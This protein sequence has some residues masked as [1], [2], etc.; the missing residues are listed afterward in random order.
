MQRKLE[1]V[2]IGFSCIGAN[3]GNEIPLLNELEERAAFQGAECIGR[4]TSS[5][6]KSES[7]SRIISF[8]S[9]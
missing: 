7:I 8:F 6:G 9:F 4:V 2:K 5:L 3:R 1:S